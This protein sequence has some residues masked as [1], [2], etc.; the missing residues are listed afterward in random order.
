MVLMY[1]E[2]EN[3]T[4]TLHEGHRGQ[5]YLLERRYATANHF[6]EVEAPDV[7]EMQA[8]GYRLA[9][10]DEQNAF[11]AAQSKKGALRENAPSGKAASTKTNGG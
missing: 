6:V 5:H 2:A 1:H 10:P 11:G 4:V 7:P 9:T 8:L 3:A